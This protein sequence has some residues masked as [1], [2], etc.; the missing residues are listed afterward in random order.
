MQLEQQAIAYKAALE[1]AEKNY[2]KQISQQNVFYEKLLS[3]AESGIVD[4]NCTAICVDM[5]KFIDIFQYLG[6]KGFNATGLEFRD[7][8]YA[9][10]PLAGTMTVLSLVARYADSTFSTWLAKKYGLKK[11]VW[12]KVWTCHLCLSQTEIRKIFVYSFV[13]NDVIYDF[14]LFSYKY[15]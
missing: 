15:Y 6:A 4:H 8:S 12:Q 1:L 14:M 9:Q 5:F 2:E 3:R 11:Q 7:W 10:S 13:I